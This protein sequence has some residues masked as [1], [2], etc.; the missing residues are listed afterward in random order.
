ML[1][2]YVAGLLELESTGTNFWNTLRFLCR[3]MV[4]EA[5]GSAEYAVPGF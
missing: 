1:Q 4:D 3:A 2:A 5:Y